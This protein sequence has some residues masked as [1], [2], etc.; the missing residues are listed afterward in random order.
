MSRKGMEKG[1]VSRRYNTPAAPSLPNSPVRPPRAAIFTP[2]S[3]V[4][5]PR[6][7]S[8]QLLPRSPTDS[9]SFDVSEEI[10]R[11]LLVVRL[12]P[13]DN[14]VLFDGQ[15]GEWA[16]TITV[17]GK[18]QASVQLIK[19]DTVERESPLNITLVQSLATS[20]KMDFIVQKAVASGPGLDSASATEAPVMAPQGDPGTLPRAPA[21]LAKS[22]P[23][24]QI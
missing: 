5:T 10:A 23:G 7:F 3:A 19:F 11:H 21:R 12:A 24:T 17:I 1:Y 20:D 15:G 4:T 13:G 8:L 18:R 2:P 16:A 6:F 22:K 14:L 9:A